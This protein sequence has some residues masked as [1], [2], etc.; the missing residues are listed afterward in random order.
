MTGVA[1]VCFEMFR[2]G[3]ETFRTGFELSGATLRLIYSGGMITNPE[4]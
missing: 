4:P 3:F 2:I 1:L